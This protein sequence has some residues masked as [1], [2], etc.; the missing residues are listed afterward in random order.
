MLVGG[1]PDLLQLA[2]SGTTHTFRMAEVEEAVRFQECAELRY[3]L[4]LKLGREIDK[5]VA[6]ENGVELQLER[7]VVQ[8]VE[9]SERDQVAKCFARFR[10][11]A[12]AVVNTEEAVAAMA[13]RKD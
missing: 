8:Q 9:N 7:I 5:H 11:V 12:N 2:R 6:A 3:D 10:F 13:P 1:D 4:R